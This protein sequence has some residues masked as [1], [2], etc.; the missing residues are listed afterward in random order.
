M[1]TSPGVGQAWGGEPS[2]AIYRTDQ[3]PEADEKS[4]PGSK[5]SVLRTI[6]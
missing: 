5:L 6:V 1:T 3:L 2:R 4:G